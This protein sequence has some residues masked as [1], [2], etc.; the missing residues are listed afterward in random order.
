MS[1]SWSLLP[2]SAVCKARPQPTTGLFTTWRTALLFPLYAL[3]FRAAYGGRVRDAA[4]ASSL[5]RLWH[6]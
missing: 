6:Y 5:A 4:V 3:H 2:L 1:G